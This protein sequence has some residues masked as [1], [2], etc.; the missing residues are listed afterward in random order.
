MGYQRVDIRLSN[1]QEL[2]DV[3]VFNA[4]EMDLPDEFAKATIT[5]I[6]SHA[7]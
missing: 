5:D 2:K 3:V 6:Q 4:A 7:A 1:G